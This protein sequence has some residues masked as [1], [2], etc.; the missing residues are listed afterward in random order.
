MPLEQG[1]KEGHEEVSRQLYR[2]WKRDSSPK[3][4]KKRALEKLE[5]KRGGHTFQTLE[6]VK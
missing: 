2:A 6:L 5:M 1:H 3:L 4:G